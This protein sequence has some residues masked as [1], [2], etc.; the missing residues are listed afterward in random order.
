[1][2]APYSSQ[3]FLFKVAIC[4]LISIGLSNLNFQSVECSSEEL[5]KGKSY[6]YASSIVQNGKLFNSLK[7]IKNDVLFRDDCLF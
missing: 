3:P 4:L 1:M 5:V 6:D 2:T 7:Y